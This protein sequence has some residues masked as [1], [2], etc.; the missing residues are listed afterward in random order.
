MRKLPYHE[1]NLLSR[2]TTLTHTTS[3]LKTRLAL[4]WRNY[5]LEIKKLRHKEGKKFLFL[6]PQQ[7]PR[8]TATRTRENPSAT[9]SKL[10]H[11]YPVKNSARSPLYAFVACINCGR[12]ESKERQN[13]R[14]S[15]RERRCVP[16]MSADS[17]RLYTEEKKSWNR[18]NL[19]SK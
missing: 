3:Q 9:S 1:N 2:Q 6:A 14:E 17:A 11:K 8:S 7:A 15:K 16:T 4:P 19:R 18:I 10:S 12:R 13:A 5:T